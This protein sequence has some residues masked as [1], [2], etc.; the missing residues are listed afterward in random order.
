MVDEGFFQRPNRRIAAPPSVHYTE[1][2]GLDALEQVREAR[3]A[4]ADTIV[5][6]A[7]ADASLR[8]GLLGGFG[9]DLKSAQLLID[10]ARQDD[11]LD[12]LLPL[13]NSLNH[14]ADLDQATI[15]FLAARNEVKS[16]RDLFAHGVF[17]YRT[18]LPDTVLI[19]SQKS[20]RKKHNDLFSR[21]IEEL[22]SDGLN[23]DFDWEV[24]KEDDFKRAQAMAF[25]LL[26][27]VH[28]MSVCWSRSPEEGEHLR[29]ELEQ[30]GLL[31][32]PPWKM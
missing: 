25:G 19:H 8:I 27:A 13:V 17:A 24:W 31:Q 16:I 23:V 5:S 10:R 7:A 6:W 1:I 28:A 12:V 14:R 22:F 11:F 18:D 30:Q 21:N 3:I 20:Y 26:N 4:I 29:L 15:K 9:N 32:Q 2:H